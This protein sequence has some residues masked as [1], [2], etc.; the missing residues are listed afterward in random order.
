MELFLTTIQHIV[1]WWNYTNVSDEMGVITF[2][3]ELSS[4]VWHFPKHNVFIIGGNMNAITYKEENDKFCVHNC[5]N[6]NGK[7]RADLSLENS[8]VCVNT[9][10]QERKKQIWI[11]IYLNNP[12]ARLDFIFI[13]EKWKNSHTHRHKH[14]DIYIYIY[15]YIYI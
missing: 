11:Y 2:Y 7:H 15:I 14:T 3:D 10:F 12:K 9:K 4:L 1:T 5:A 6:S 13:N 8:L